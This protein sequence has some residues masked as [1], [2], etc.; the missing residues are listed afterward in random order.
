MSFISICILAASSPYPSD[1]SDW[2]FWV[3]LAALLAFYFAFN[4]WS[5]KRRRRALAHI[6]PSMGFLWLNT[7]PETPR[8]IAFPQSSGQ[9]SLF[10]LLSVSL[11]SAPGLSLSLGRI[12]GAYSSYPSSEI[13]PKNGPTMPDTEECSRQDDQRPQRNFGASRR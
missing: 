9:V 2:R 1:W 4:S 10:C 3:F 13:W 12:R 5:A 11:E 7:M 8:G 6:A